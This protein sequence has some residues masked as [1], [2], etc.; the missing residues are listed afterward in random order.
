MIHKEHPELAGDSNFHTHPVS[1]CHV[2]TDDV[3]SIPT[4]DEAHHVAVKHNWATDFTNK[5]ITQDKV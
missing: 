2:L 1:V 5:M 3:Y 4:D